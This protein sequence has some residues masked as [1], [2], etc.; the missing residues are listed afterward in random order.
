[1]QLIDGISWV[2]F[3]A[4]SSKFSYGDT[5]Y[6]TESLTFYCLVA[7]T[8]RTKQPTHPTQ[9]LSSPNADASTIRTP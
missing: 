1:M 7:T 2:T 5:E 4:T 3:R 6:I 8:A 9:M